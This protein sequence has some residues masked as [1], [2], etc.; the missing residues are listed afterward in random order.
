VLYQLPPTLPRDLP[1]LQDFLAALPSDRRAA[2]EFRHRSWSSD[3]VL[4]ALAQAGAALCVADTDEGT[5][6]LIATARFGYLRLRRA[7]YGA[8]ELRAWAHRV[9]A[10][11]WSQAVVFFK[12]EDEA[13]GPALALAFAELL[14]GGEAAPTAQGASSTT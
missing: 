6:P 7:W 4:A 1:L 5:T 9:L 10:L 2:F 11:P 12:H 3:G 14:Q 13:R 8:D